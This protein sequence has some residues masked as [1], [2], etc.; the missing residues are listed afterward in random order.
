MKKTVARPSRTAAYATDLEYL[1]HLLEWV[2]C[3]C[4]LI[5]AGRALDLPA[6]DPELGDDD[7]RGRR[8]REF[9]R[10]GDRFTQ[11]M[12]EEPRLRADIAARLKA[13]TAFVP[14]LE[15]LCTTKG[16]DKFERNV[17]LLALAPSF[18][19][20]F[21]TLYG[22]IARDRIRGNAPTVEVVFEFMELPFADRVRYRRYFAPK[23]KLLKNDLIS[24]GFGSRLET[25]D[26]LLDSDIEMPT[27]TFNFLVGER[28][29]SDEFQEFSS[30]EE[31][32]ATLE[33]VV[34]P[35]DDKRRILSVVERH[36]KFL[37]FR[38]KWGFDEVIRYGKGVLMLFH[39][40]PGT[41]KTLTAHAIAHHMGKRVL[42]VDIPTLIEN[43][44]ADRFLPGL[45]RE[46]RLQ[47]ALLF[48]DEC[49]TIFASRRFGNSLMTLLLT[50]LER[51]EGIAVLAT[52]LPETLDEALDRRVLVKVQF[53][54][55]DR[56]AR[57][58]IWRRHLPAQAPL[59]SDV[60]LETLAERYDMAG[61]YIK[62]AVL[63]AVADAVHSDG[64]SPIIRMEHL[65]R[66]AKSQQVRPIDDT[67]ALQ[68]P[69]ATL[70]DVILPTEIRNQLEELV[71]A[72][73]NRRTVLDRWGI[74]RHLSRGKGVSAL[75]HGDPGTGKTL[76][77]EAVAAE[78]G[79]PI[80]VASVPS[81]VSKWVGDTEKNLRNLFS[82][83]RAS[84]AVLFLDEADSLLMERGEGRA[85]RHDDSAVNTFLQLLEEQDGVVLLATNMASRLDKALAR[86]LTYMLRFPT[87]DA[88]ARAAIWRR[89][90]PESVPTQGDLRLD[91][92]ADAFA[93]SGGQIRNAVF[94]AA[95][96]AARV[97]QL[98][99]HEMLRQAASEELGAVADVRGVARAIGFTN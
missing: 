54:E 95:F 41:G 24:M 29:L 3:K 43:R 2:E 13:S 74:G 51:F 60:D 90:L 71:A 78:L 68:Q 94:K 46:A 75:F 44:D 84:E 12:H 23:G 62:N 50:E 18:S 58:E 85:S 31:P 20:R 96:R 52:N 56:A 5:L 25:A 76:A 42:N 28:G 48:F 22:A 63:M 33:Q 10:Q 14:S 70:A 82:E 15:S 59:H 87:P 26:S 49:E 67:K 32:M 93:L 8:P 66:A 37:E 1:E 57:L 81:L 72:A 73:R 30:I 77:A 7:D 61:G 47:N 16:L 17:L 45:F 91:A 65:Q 98:L 55:P 11:L 27:R 53:H 36:D 69:L 97:E 39:G 9:D 38:Q 64:D 89:H 79:R 83:V 6:E 80:R 19:K 88:A 34:L 35:A 4:R 86:R 99:S 40:K 21:S 92:L